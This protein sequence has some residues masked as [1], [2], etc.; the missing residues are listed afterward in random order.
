MIFTYFSVF[1]GFQ[2]HLENTGLKNVLCFTVT[3]PLKTIFVL[4]TELTFWDV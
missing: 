1:C 4:F 3:H 2:T